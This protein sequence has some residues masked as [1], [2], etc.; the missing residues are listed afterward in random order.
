MISHGTSIS[1]RPLI[2]LVHGMVRIQTHAIY[3]KVIDQRIVDELL[4]TM[5]C[6]TE[7]LLNSTP[8]VSNSIYPTDLEN[9][10]VNRFILC[11]P[12]VGLC[13]FWMYRGTTTTTAMYFGWL[14]HIWTIFEHDGYKNLYHCI[15]LDRNGSMNAE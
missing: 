3:H 2:L 12:S 15:L 6:L 13:T 9:F 1:L 8:L 7:Q 4:I 14:K 5:L 10:R 11:R